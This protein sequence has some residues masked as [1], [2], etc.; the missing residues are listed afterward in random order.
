[1][2]PSHRS[3]TTG[4]PKGAI[5]THAN[6]VAGTA[7]ARR[8]GVVVGTGDFY[9]SF[10]P[11]AHVA[12]QFAELLLL[13]DGAAIGFYRGDV[14]LLMDDIKALRP[15]FFVAVP[16]LYTRCVV[17]G[18]AVGGGCPSPCVHAPSLPCALSCRHR[19]I[20]DR[21]MAGAQGA[22]G[23]KAALFRMAMEGKQYWLHHGGHQHHVVWDRLVFGPIAARVGL[24]RVRMMVSGA[25]PIGPHILEFL[26]VVFGARV[27]EA[28]GQT[29]C[30]GV[31]TVTDPEDPL[32]S[33]HVGC[34][35]PEVEVRLDSVPELGYRATDTTHGRTVDAAGAVTNPGEC[36]PTRWQLPLSRLWQPA[37]CHCHRSHRDAMLGAWRGVLPWLQCVQRVLCRRSQDTGGAG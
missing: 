10:L 17:H 29:E 25:A 24:D 12:E 11:L 30:S 14:A 21:I 7:P 36:A 15:T 34:V 26:R 4:L 35:L 2:P 6:L 13:T 18:Q 9:L 31:A 3:G 20:Y 22:G 27:V 16:R 32:A 33:G 19:S 1:M 37:H 5:L 8:C 28:Y 23:V